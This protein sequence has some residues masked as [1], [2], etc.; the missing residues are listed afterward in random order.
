MLLK[1][2]RFEAEAEVDI[3]RCPGGGGARLF[4]LAVLLRVRG[5]EVLVLSAITFG[6]RAFRSDCPFIM[7]N[8]ILR[9][10]YTL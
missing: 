9:K 4:G 7:F 10:W 6:S 3:G 1:E 5:G 2:D 8:L